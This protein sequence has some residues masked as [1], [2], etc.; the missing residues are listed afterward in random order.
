MPTGS[1]L[2][3]FACC[4]CLRNFGKE[5]RLTAGLKRPR[6]TW[7][8]MMD[9]D[10][11]HPPALVADMLAHGARRRRGV[12]SAQDRVRRAA[13]QAVGTHLFYQLLNRFDR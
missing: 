7:W 2:P 13:V 12:R 5:A 4:S 9:A 1:E 6:A 8:C 10:L 11:Q 3:G